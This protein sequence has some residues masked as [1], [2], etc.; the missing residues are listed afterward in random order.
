MASKMD[1]S[2]KEEAKNSNLVIIPKVV[3]KEKKAIPAENLMIRAK[4]VLRVQKVAPDTSMRKVDTK[5]DTTTKAAI[6][7]RTKPVL[8]ERKDPATQKRADTKRAIR[9]LGSTT[10]T[11][12]MNLKKTTRSTTTPTRV[13]N[14]SIMEISKVDMQVLR[15]LTQRAEIWT[16]AILVV[17]LAKKANS[18]KGSILMRRAAT[19]VERDK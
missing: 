2:K 14:R 3:P 10:Y 6:L 8:K 18:T 1:I 13:A 15:A 5:K 7:V 16:A 11:T 12:K 9:P 19:K 17:I 4:R